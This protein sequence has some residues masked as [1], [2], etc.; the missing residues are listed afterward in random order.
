MKVSGAVFVGQGSAM[1][2]EELELA[3]PGLGEVLVRY[4]ASARAGQ[5]IVLGGKA[6]ALLAGRPAVALTD[7]EAC[8]LPA[9]RHRVL[10]GF[11]ADAERIHVDELLQIWRSAAQRRT[12]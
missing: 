6:R 7:I 1:P 11:E 2:V 12:T 9:L 3:D 5:A 8:L 4:G 10:L